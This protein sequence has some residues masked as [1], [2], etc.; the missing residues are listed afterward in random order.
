MRKTISIVLCL[1][2]LNANCATITC[3]PDQEIQITSTPEG[4]HVFVD[5]VP[6]GK[7]PMFRNLVRKRSHTLRFELE[8][9]EEHWSTVSRGLNPWL[10]GNIVFGWLIGFVV[11]I[12]TGSSGSLT[13]SHVH[14]ELTPAS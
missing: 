9:Y 3:G 13:P 10:F 12:A 4:A 11:D 1:M 7:T 6:Q 8:G 5:G 2:L 14:A